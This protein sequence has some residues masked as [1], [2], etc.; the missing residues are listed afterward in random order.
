MIVCRVLNLWCPYAT[1]LPLLCRGGEGASMWAC[2]CVRHSVS[3]SA[4]VVRWN[5]AYCELPCKHT[6]KQNRPPIGTP[7]PLQQ[8]QQRRVFHFRLSWFR[9]SAA[10]RA[11]YLGACSSSC[12]KSWERSHRSKDS[13]QVPLQQ[14]WGL[15]QVSALES[16]LIRHSSKSD[17]KKQLFFGHGPIY[18]LSRPLS[19]LPR[20]TSLLAS[21]LFPCISTR[22]GRWVSFTLHSRT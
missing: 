8:K 1:A 4:K 6:H 22:V 21:W 13:C 11:A 3:V 17:W 19:V 12:P 15:L 10:G 9:C 18:R 2:I 14:A 7:L 5:L 16:V 20:L